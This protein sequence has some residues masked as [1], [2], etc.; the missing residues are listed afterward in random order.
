MKIYNF[1]FVT[2][3][4]W[5]LDMAIKVQSEWNN[6][7]LYV[8]KESDK[9][10]WDWLVEKTDSWESEISWADIIVFESIWNGEKIKKLRED[11][12]MVIWWTPYTDKLEDNRCFWQQELKKHKVKTL[13]FE[14]FE[15][16]DDAIEYVRQKPWK[17]VIKPSWE[18]Q[19]LKQLVFIW[20]EE[21]GSDVARVLNAYKKTWWNEIWLFQLQKKVSWVEIAVWAFFNGKRFLK[22]IN[23]N[24]EHKKLFP[25]ELWV[26][27]WEMGTSMFWED[28]NK[29]FEETLMKFEKTL[30][31]EWYTWYIDINCIVNANWIYPLE[32]TC[33]FG[34]PTILI[35]QDA[36]SMRFSDF[37][38]N[39]ANGEDFKI[40]VKK[41]FQIWVMIVVPP[42]PYY[43]LKTF[44]TFS[45]DAIIVLKDK[46]KN[47]NGIHL[48][49][50]KK[51]NWELLITWPAGIALVVTGLGNTMKEAQKQAYTRIQNILIPN[52]Y[53]RND[54][55][56]RWY[57]DSDKLRSWEYL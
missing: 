26:P 27:T 50:L 37:L 48:Q 14:E 57:E 8:W 3:E 54:I 42:F 20:N 23:V 44:E 10:T 5:L 32:F 18:I 25:G 12:K 55:W 9:E 36:I 45:K 21:D 51:V 4:W 6:V 52:M 49:E 11:W 33:R 24:F 47:M 38:I 2:K 30:S 1:L 15:S 22:P 19:D 17:Y 39:I 16:F 13:W 7:K 29:I 46:K 28:H 31:L 40:K 43:D 34:Y 56:N 41:W 53:Y 35:Q